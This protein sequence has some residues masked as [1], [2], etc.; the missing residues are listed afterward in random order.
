M[1]TTNKFLVSNTSFDPETLNL[2]SDAFEDA[3]LKIQTS[4]NRLARPGY[5]SVMREVMAK[6]IIHLAQRGERDEIALSNG[7]VNFFTAN[8]KA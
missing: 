5:A 8:Y 4:G 2:L 3:W 6:H 1:I 7:A